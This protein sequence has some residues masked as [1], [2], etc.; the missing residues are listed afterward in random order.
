MSWRSIRSG[1]LSTPLLSRPATGVAGVFLDRPT[2]R[3]IGQG[4]LLLSACGQLNTVPLRSKAR[5]GPAGR[6]TASV[7]TARDS[8]QPDSAGLLK[9]V[10]I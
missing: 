8:A 5:C 4:G 9:V 10:H 6:I 2:V 3:P 7:M 1:S